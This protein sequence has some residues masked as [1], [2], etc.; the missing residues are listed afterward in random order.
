MVAAVAGSER[1]GPGGC[2]EPRACTAGRA[3]TS[4]VVRAAAIAVGVACAAALTAGCGGQAAGSTAGATPGRTANGTANPA[5]SSG[6]ADSADSSDSAHTTKVA[7]PQ[8][9]APAT[10]DQVR[11]VVTAADALVAAA[12]SRVTTAMRMAGGGTWLTVTG[13]GGFDYARGWGE[14]TVLLPRDAIGKEE[15]KPITELLTPGALYMKNRGAGVPA[16]KWVRLDTTR[17]ADGDLVTGGAT[18]PLAAAE[19]LRGARGVRDMGERTVQGV[20]VTHFTGVTDIARAAAAAPAAVRAPLAAAARGFTVTRVPFEAW[21]DPYGRLR[22]LT[23]TF[24]FSTVGARRTPGQNVTVVST[25]TYDG[26]GTPVRVTLPR[27]A[28]IWTGKIVSAQP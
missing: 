8:A 14:L 6:S 23:E 4:P 25:I 10:A 3:R 27:T 17:L 21:L 19:L 2:A 15:H 18:E 26:F 7:R 9:P 11:A 28:D 24:T 16:D 22:R 1:T 5:N 13:I 12:R 20:K